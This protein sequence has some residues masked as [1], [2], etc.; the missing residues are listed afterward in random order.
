MKKLTI[1]IPAY[2]EEKAICKCLESIIKQ[3]DLQDVNITISVI[4]NHCN[5]DTVD[6]VQRYINSKNLKS[7]DI[8]NIQERGKSK[9]L[10][11]GLKNIKTD[12]FAVMDADCVL[13]ENCVRKIVAEFEDNKK[14]KI[15]GALDKPLFKETKSL[16][17]EYQVTQQI[18][19][20]E[21]GRVL[22]VG[23]FYMFEGNLIEE[24]PE[25]LHSEDTWLDLHI[26][27]AYG[28]NAVKVLMEAIVY[29]TPAQNWIDFIKQESRFE[30]G[31]PQIINHFPKLLQVWENRR[32]SSQVE[33]S[34]KKVFE[35]ITQRLQNM[36]INESRITEFDSIIADIIE[37]NSKIMRYDLISK[38]GI[39]EP[40]NSTKG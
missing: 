15:V 16:L 14:L 1:L 39:W 30:C 37:D 11:Y 22:P 32:R 6:V 34:K 31:L 18:Y 29:F 36:N 2:N 13:E 23:R 27:S 9:A 28:W 8:Y 38:D 26:A 19:R 5:D 21:R 4:A 33:Y 25:F 17:Y 24:F 35:R 10:N 20:E 7:I 12:Y 3:N 40:I